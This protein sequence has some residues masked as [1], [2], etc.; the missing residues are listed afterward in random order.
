MYLSLGDCIWHCR[1]SLIVAWLKAQ[2][3]LYSAII[4]TLVIC[5]LYLI[6]YIWP[7]HNYD[8]TGCPAVV[9]FNSI[10]KR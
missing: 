6:S 5:L 1:V 4:A 3:L 8:K 9:K 2:L 10:E 7:Q